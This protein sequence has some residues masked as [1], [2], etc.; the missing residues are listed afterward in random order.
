VR[1]CH[2][3]N[4]LK[5]L[6]DFHKRLNGYQYKCKSCNSKYLKNYNKERRSVDLNFKLK[7]N[8]RVRIRTSLKRNYKSGSAVKDL[9]CSIDEF[10]I[11]LESK[12]QSGMTWDNWGN[13][14]GQW[15]IDHINPLSQFD[16]TK[17]E[18]FKNAC[19]YSNLQPLWVKDNLYKNRKI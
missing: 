12:F 10:K 4:T 7:Y 15:S 8:L 16:L 2:I 3:C 11:Y 17:Q 1:N 6:S 9:G 13:R 14:I 18:D 19:H 5:P